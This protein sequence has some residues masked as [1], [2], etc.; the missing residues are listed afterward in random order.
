M[1]RLRAGVYLSAALAVALVAA[2]LYGNTHFT[3]PKR[4]VVPS[5]Y[6]M[7]KEVTLQGTVQ[8]VHAKPTAAMMF[9]AY[10]TVATAQG[11]VDA[12]VGRFLLHGPRA[13][14]FS[15]GQQVKLVGV[16]TTVN[17]RSVLLT[18]LIETGTQTITVRNERGFPAPHGA[19]LRL[20]HTST[21][22]GAR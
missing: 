16:M 12:Q 19:Y 21:A 9:G 13:L 7:A 6:S 1:K 20:T 5:R 17:H 10:L 18:R 15:R 3:R 8:S 22:G 14:S 2:P 4:A 11:T